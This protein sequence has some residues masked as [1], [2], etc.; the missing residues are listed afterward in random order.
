M[1][2]VIVRLPLD[3]ACAIDLHRIQARQETGQDISR[4]SIVYD[5]LCTSF[6]IK[7]LAWSKSRGRQKARPKE[8][9]AV[10]ES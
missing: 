3:I 4:E 7:P 1:K 10:I 5:R 9:M 6:G 8:I 2:F